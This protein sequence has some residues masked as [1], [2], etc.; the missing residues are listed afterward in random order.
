MAGQRVGYKRVSTLD[1]RL[2]RQLD[3][4]ELDEIFEDRVSGK[5]LNRPQWEAARKYLRKGDILFVHSMDR[6]AR[7]L[8]DLLGAVQE[9]NEKGVE[10]RFVTENLNFG[11]DGEG[12]P[13]ARLM[14]SMLGAVAE[15]ERSLILE[16][17][18]EGIALARKRGA[19]RGR[20]RVITPEMLA[21]ARLRM[22]AGEKVSRVARELG[23]S[24]QTIYSYL[25]QNA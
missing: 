4:L 20:K 15:F 18:Q 2:D 5:D 23:V 19:Y 14:L 1:Q 11:P 17:Q 8:K 24:R 7:N 13:M 16:R 25:K 10:V 9:M 12:H 22:A 6:L 21:Q 3:G